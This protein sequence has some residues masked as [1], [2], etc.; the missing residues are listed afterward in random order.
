MDVLRSIG[1]RAEMRANLRFG[2]PARLFAGSAALRERI[3]QRRRGLCR[4]FF[5]GRCAMGERGAVFQV[6]VAPL[7]VMPCSASPAL[8]EVVQEGAGEE[9]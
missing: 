7:S 3:E 1:L 9:R 4:L 2:Q 8:G 5:D 6:D